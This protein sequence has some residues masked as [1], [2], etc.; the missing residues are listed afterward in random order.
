MKANEAN[1]QTIID[2]A[3]LTALGMMR[4]AHTT[5]NNELAI[6]MHLAFDMICDAY[7][8]PFKSRFTKAMAIVR[9]EKLAT[10]SAKVRRIA[11][12]KRLGE[13]RRVLNIDSLCVTVDP[14]SKWMQEQSCII[15]RMYRDI[16]MK[17]IA[18]LFRKDTE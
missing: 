18:E 10:N 16:I 11:A 8:L 17:E 5:Q 6:A 4:I 14:P 9:R 13:I 3:T 7:D 15:I 1:K 2:D 12:A